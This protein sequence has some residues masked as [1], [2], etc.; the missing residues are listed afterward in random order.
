MKSRALNRSLKL[1][2]YETLIRP[3]VTYRCEAWTLTS[4]NEQ[5]LRIFLVQH[6]TKMEFGESERTM[7]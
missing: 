2:I 6:K 4:Q 3:T 7:N 1:K 5:Q